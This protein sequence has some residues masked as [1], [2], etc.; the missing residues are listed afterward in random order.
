[1]LRIRDIMTV[2]I[3]AL[4]PQTTLREAMETFALRHVSGAPVL[5][6]EQVVGVV[7]TTDLVGFA[8][9]LAGIPTEQDLRSA[10]ELAEMPSLDEHGEEGAFGRFFN[11]P[12]DDANADVSDHI[13]ATTSLQWNMLE[14]HDVDEV[15]TR[16]PLITVFPDSSAEMAA[17]LMR[18]HNVH[19]VLVTDGAGRLRGIVTSLDIAKAVADHRF[20]TRTFVFDRRQVVNDA[21]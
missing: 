11:E 6:G 10:W 8:A 5:N 13:A 14:A 16:A 2:D 12:W 7:S 17:E 9:S 15:M 19:R 21:S 18:R 3:V 4:A 20:S 1:M